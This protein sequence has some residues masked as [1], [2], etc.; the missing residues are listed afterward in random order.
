MSLRRADRVSAILERLAGTG[1]IDAGRLAEEFA[2]SPATIR[3]DLQTL[4][5]QR[6]LS[7]THGGAVAVDAAYELPVRYRGGQ[8]REEKA[9]IAKATADLLPKG[10]LTLGLTGGTTTHL[11]SRLLAER[12]DLTVVTNAL[13]IAAELA[14]RPRLKL[15]MTGGVSRTQSYEL[16]GPIADQALQ[17]LNMEVA[18]V[19][20]DGI[21]ARGGLTTHD[22]IEA[23]TN[24]TMI[25]RADRVIVVADGSKV[26]KVCLAGICPITGV[27]TLVTDTGADPAA[28]DAIRRTGTE[29]VV[30][31]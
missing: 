17:G 18:V 6:L 5:D 25:R 8:H 16:V 28:L 26:G 23:N 20:V 4:E 3:R 27:A 12:V 24:A 30:A 31:G 21:S 22:E 11:L 19:G 10:P 1:S 15:I 9:L 2:V 7:R 29:V 14:L 13:N